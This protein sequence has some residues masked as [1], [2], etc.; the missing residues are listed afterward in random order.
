MGEKIKDP[1]PIGK[2]NK[3]E[4][5]TSMMHPKLWAHNSSG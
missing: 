1:Q 5:D 4:D 3:S 2:V